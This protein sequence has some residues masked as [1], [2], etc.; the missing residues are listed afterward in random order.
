MLPN[1]RTSHWRDQLRSLFPDPDFD[2]LY[3]FNALHK[4]VLGLMNSQSVQSVLVAEPGLIDQ[5]D[6]S[7]KTALG[8]A[9]RRTDKDT[10]RT[11]ASDRTN[12]NHKDRMGVPPL[13]FATMGSWECVNLLLEAGA[14]PHVKDDI[15]RNALHYVSHSSALPGAEVLHI[16]D[17]LL[18]AGVDIH[19]VSSDGETPLM[20]TNPSG[21]VLVAEYLIEHGAVV[22]ACDTN[23]DNILWNAVSLNRHTL[24]DLLLSK[25][26]DHTTPSKQRGSFLHLAAELADTKTLQ[27]LSKGM[28]KQRNINIKNEA[29]KTPHNLGM[30]R[31]NV[32]LAWRHAFSDFLASV[33][34]DLLSPEYISAAP[35]NSENVNRPGGDRFGNTAGGDST[36]S[37]DDF[38]DA[39]EVQA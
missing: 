10:I 21:H 5:A 38:E 36:G 17:S 14:D 8:W 27:L 23:G 32:D 1:G 35:V 22:E 31:R 3:G 25:G 16:A 19:A 39:V 12:L 13:L 37:D 29:G 26:L 34:E 30:Q 6:F 2:E 20:R 18:N 28:L 9:T 11:L 4:A 7:G 33:D 24:I 15:G